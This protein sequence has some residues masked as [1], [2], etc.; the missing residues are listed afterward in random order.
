VEA[1]VG[2]CHSHRQAE[3]AVSLLRAAGLRDLTLLTPGETRHQIESEVKSEDME[4]RGVGEAI[5]GVV[6]GA[7][8]M[9]GGSQLGTA[10]ALLIPGVGSILGFGLLGAVL[11]GLG[12][13]AAGIA[14]G[15]TVE[16][17]FGD[18]LPKDDL[19]VCEEALRQG[20][21]VLV[22]WAHSDSAAHTARELLQQAGA[23]SLETARRR[24]ESR[25]VAHASE[26]SSGAHLETT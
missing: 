16:T 11:I 25:D 3:Q 12:G 8:G 9:A 14:A 23:Q 26:P 18:G 22:A 20:Q 19:V 2:I 21:T 1:I 5:A 7:V 10:V 4:G 17:S 6:G 24:T 13:V 15:R